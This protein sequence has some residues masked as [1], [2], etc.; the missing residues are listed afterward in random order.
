MLKRD[1]LKKLLNYESA[2]IYITKVENPYTTTTRRNRNRE[3]AYTIKPAQ[4]LLQLKKEI[5]SRCQVLPVD[6]RLFLNDVLLDDNSKTMSELRI[7][8]NC[9]LKLEVDRP[10][11]DNIDLI[12]DEP[13]SR[14]SCKYNP[15]LQRKEKTSGFSSLSDQ[16]CLIDLSET[17]L[18]LLILA[19]V[20]NSE[21]KE[22]EREELS[23]HSLHKRQ[24][25]ICL[26][27]L[28]MVSN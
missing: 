11:T 9:S 24:P 15:F 28:S 8:P 1:E 20:A 21:E 2:T 27:T 13:T 14:K 12:E 17:R 25:R 26:S 16:S 18:I 4:T 5:F 22:Y 10:A 7:V 3:H 19:S 23:L 6:Q